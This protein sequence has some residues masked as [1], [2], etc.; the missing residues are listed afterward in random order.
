MS[1]ETIQLVSDERGDVTAV[2]VPIELWKDITSRVETNHLLASET[3][4]RRLLEA[5]E[6]A[7]SASFDD[8]MQRLGIAQDELR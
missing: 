5:M 7:D 4:K 3:M 6:D 8:A 2:I 1:M